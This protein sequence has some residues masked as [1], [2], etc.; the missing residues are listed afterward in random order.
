MTKRDR[1]ATYVLDI[2]DLL[3]GIAGSREHTFEWLA[4]D[5]SPKTGRCRLL[6]VD[7]Y[8]ESLRLVVEVLETQHWMETPH[9]DKPDV[10]TV[11]GVHRGLQR[12]LYDQRRVELVPLHG[13]ELIAIPVSAFEV[14][15]KKIVRQPESD[16][17]VVRGL[18][19]KAGIA[20]A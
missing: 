6:P 16:V 12:K 10:L 14:R 15:S 8:W 2:C 9:F 13:L 4:G 3:L 18:L 1:D 20:L 7:S 11:S 17:E 5:L 19:V